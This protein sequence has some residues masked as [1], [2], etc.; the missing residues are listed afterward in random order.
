MNN[1]A[2]SPTQLVQVHE[3]SGLAVRKVHMPG[4]DAVSA[5]ARE[6]CA[7]QPANLPPQPTDIPSPIGVGYTNDRR[8]NSEGWDFQPDIRAGICRSEERRV[9]KE[10]RSR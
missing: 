9:G 2:V 7:L 4:E 1:N 6:G 8:A 5:P 10:C 3:R